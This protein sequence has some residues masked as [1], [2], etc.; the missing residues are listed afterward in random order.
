MDFLFRLTHDAD[1]KIRVFTIAGR[2][3]REMTHRGVGGD[4]V[5]AWDGTDENGSPLA[6]GTYLF[7][8]EA[9]RRA[10]DGS[11]ENDEVVG[12]VVRMR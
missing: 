3:V 2:L 8:L 12:K 1:V 4:N 7:K 10:A 5:V 6:N 11:L 9:E